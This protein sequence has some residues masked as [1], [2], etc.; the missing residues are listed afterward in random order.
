[1]TDRERFEAWA[2]DQD[3]IVGLS[4]SLEGNYKDC[5]AF[6][7]WDAWQASRKQALADARQECRKFLA[8][9]PS[10]SMDDVL[11]NTAVRYCAAA[12]DALANP[13]GE[14]G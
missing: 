3:E 4:R 12:I 10:T 5:A 6:V 9:G 7:A 1:M 14:Q 11:K 2:R 8:S 13:E